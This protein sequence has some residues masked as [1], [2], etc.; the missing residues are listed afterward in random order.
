METAPHFIHDAISRTP[1]LSAP[2]KIK[3]SDRTHSRSREMDPETR[4]TQLEEALHAFLDTREDAIWLYENV[5][6]EVKEAYPDI[7]LSQRNPE[8]HSEELTSR[9][10]ND[11][12]QVHGNE[13]RILKVQYI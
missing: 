4:V 9:I 6:R 7:Q 8:S 11:S 2:R 10:S 1:S 13:L 12:A 3:N 5:R